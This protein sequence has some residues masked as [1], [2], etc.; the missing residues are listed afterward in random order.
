MGGPQRGQWTPCTIGEPAQP[1]I[2]N[3]KCMLPLCVC[4]CNHRSTGATP[5]NPGQM[6]ESLRTC[7]LRPHCNWGGDVLKLA[8][9]DAQTCEALSL[10]PLKEQGKGKGSNMSWQTVLLP[11]VKGWLFGEEIARATFASFS[12]THH[13]GKLC[14]PFK[15]KNKLRVGYG[16][17]ELCWRPLYGISLPPL[18]SQNS[19]T[20]KPFECCI[21]KPM[22]NALN[23]QI[24]K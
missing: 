21:Q 9:H 22:W 20:S 23:S 3:A 16:E 6:P 24:K 15:A 2:N 10:P 1:P 4:Q 14:L 8:H 13:N 19:C 17:G 18:R 12:P 11:G 7:V 5:S